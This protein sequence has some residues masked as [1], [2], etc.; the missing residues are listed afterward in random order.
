MNFIKNLAQYIEKK[1]TLKTA[2][3]EDRIVLNF[4]EKNYQF[5][6]ENNNF[7]DVGS[8][9]GRFLEVVRKKFNSKFKLSCLEINPDLVQITRQAG[10]ETTECNI[11]DL[12][13]TDNTFDIVH[14]SHVIEH[15]GYPQIIQVLDKLLQIVKS[16]GYVI[17]RSP[18][19]HSNFYLDIDHVRPYSPECIIGYFQN[20]Q[21][22]RVG[23]FKIKEVIRWYRREAVQLEI[24]MDIKYIKKIIKLINLMLKFF[25]IFIKFPM[26]KRNGYVFIIQKV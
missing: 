17:I 10:I 24:W 1:Y 7:F 16:Q 19:W 6:P 25:W 3:R 2:Q 5:L 13:P 15:F 9:L 20:L 14:C 26:S 11:L 23:S 12:H 18:L 8:G 22:Q 21:Q 4:I